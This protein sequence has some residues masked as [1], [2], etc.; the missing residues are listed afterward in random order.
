[1]GTGMFI[2]LAILRPIACLFVAF[3]KTIISWK[4]TW[5][6]IKR[7]MG[8]IRTSDLGKLFGSVIAKFYQGYSFYNAKSNTTSTSFTRQSKVNRTLNMKEMRGK[9]A[10]I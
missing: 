4:Y 3:V 8:M 9:T 1:M 5:E 7:D 2:D 10:I 6:E